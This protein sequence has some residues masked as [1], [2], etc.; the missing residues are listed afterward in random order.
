MTW[1]APLFPA[2][3]APLSRIRRAACVVSDAFWS[4]HPDYRAEQAF[5]RM[6]RLPFMGVGHA[7]R[8]AIALTVFIR[9]QGDD[10]S[11]LVAPTTHLLDEAAIR[12]CRLAGTA[13]RLAHTLT[14][15]APGLIGRTRLSAINGELVLEVPA[16]N[17][18]F[19]I[20]PDRSFDRLA[21][22]VGC[23]T[24]VIRRVG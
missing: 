22:A 24:L 21:R 1:M 18:A 19:L 23:E 3:P 9:Y 14:G 20:D 10:D 15:G 12:R 6:L 2:E 17:P 5:L 7:D 11:P 4:E 13:L 8:A 16:G